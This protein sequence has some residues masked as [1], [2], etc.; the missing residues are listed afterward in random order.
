MKF[1]LLITKCTLLLVFVVSSSSEGQ[2]TTAPMERNNPCNYEITF[3][4]DLTSSE[5]QSVIIENPAI[6]NIKYSLY[7]KDGKVFDAKT[8]QPFE[9]ASNKDIPA[10][11]MPFGFSE[12]EEFV[13]YSN[14]VGRIMLYSAQNGEFKGI[15]P[16]EE[17]PIFPR[18]ISRT[19]IVSPDGEKIAFLSHYDGKKSSKRLLSEPAVTLFGMNSFQQYVLV[20]DL[21]GT[22]GLVAAIP[23]SDC[24]ADFKLKLRYYENTTE[25]ITEGGLEG[26]TSDPK[27]GDWILFSNDNKKIV[28]RQSLYHLNLYDFGAEKVS[29]SFDLMT[30]GSYGHKMIASFEWVNDE[31]LRIHL[32]DTSMYSKATPPGKNLKTIEW[33]AN[34]GT[35]K[36]TEK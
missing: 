4:E 31:V 22:Q 3:I 2:S 10:S 17:W 1:S 25:G 5:T 16:N 30:M 6:R 34:K 14:D 11:Y 35:V 32:M 15:F 13:C 8:D 33:D 23:C 24:Y 7:V 36:E 29:V 12:N 27:A 20:S 19:P 26:V 18:L 9:V 21:N 28:V